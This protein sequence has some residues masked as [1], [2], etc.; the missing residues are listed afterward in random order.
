M[1]SFK[2]PIFFSKLEI[3]EMSL[4]GQSDSMRFLQSIPASQFENRDKT[5]PLYT[6]CW[7]H[8]ILRCNGLP[9]SNIAASHKNEPRQ[10]TLEVKTIS[11]PVS[12]FK[13]FVA[14]L[15]RVSL[16]KLFLKIIGPPVTDRLSLMSTTG[17]NGWTNFQT[18][19]CTE[20]SVPSQSHICK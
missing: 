9:D 8:R 19:L 15:K 18:R 5:V 14:S 13:W 11:V 20:Y 10:D 4:S 17:S 7:F 12:R 6:A 3:T 1:T 16:Y 2:S